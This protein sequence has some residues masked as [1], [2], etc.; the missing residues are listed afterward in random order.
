MTFT[1]VFIEGLH[2]KD[3]LYNLVVPGVLLTFEPSEPKQLWELE[4]ANNLQTDAINKAKCHRLL[5]AI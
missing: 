4:E 3:R 5:S 2:I 1:E